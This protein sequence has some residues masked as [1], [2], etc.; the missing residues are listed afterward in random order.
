MSKMIIALGAAVMGASAL[1]PVPAAALPTCETEVSIRCSGYGVNGKPRLDIYYDSYEEC[2][3]QET[4]L[5]CPGSLPYAP[6]SE[7]ASS[8][9]A[10]KDF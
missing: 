6:G 1:A 8:L 10:V 2:V 7:G 4:A 9:V 5:R 3:E